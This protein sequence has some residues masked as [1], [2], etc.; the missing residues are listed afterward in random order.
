MPASDEER[1]NTSDKERICGKD[2]HPAEV[3]PSLSLSLSLRCETTKKTKRISPQRNVEFKKKEGFSKPRVFIEKI[4]A[5]AFFF[6][7]I[8]M[9]PYY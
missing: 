6:N 7:A 9:F 8:L 3:E 5:N 2:N 4:D 1:E